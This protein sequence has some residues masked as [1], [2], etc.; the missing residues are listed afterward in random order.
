MIAFVLENRRVRF[1]INAAAAERAGLK[2]SS[3]LLS[4]AKSVE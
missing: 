2:L 1:A 4:V 3:K